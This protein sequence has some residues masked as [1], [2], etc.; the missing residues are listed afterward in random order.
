MAAK[1]TTSLQRVILEVLAGRDDWTLGLDLVQA[2]G[3]RLRRGTVDAY[4]AEFE[5]ARVVVSRVRAD[6]RREYKITSRGR[7]VLPLDDL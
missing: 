2:S 1:T 6:G 3:S 4:L 5:R 7:A